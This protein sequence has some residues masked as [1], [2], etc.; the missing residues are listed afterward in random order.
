MIQFT[1]ERRS[2]V[3]RCDAGI[4]STWSEGFPRWGQG[5][6]AGSL[7]GQQSQFETE[8][9]ADCIIRIRT[10]AASVQLRMMFGFK[11]QQVR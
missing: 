7:I 2:L 8:T 4:R 6:F 9:I 3:A 5:L 10:M 1:M 11:G